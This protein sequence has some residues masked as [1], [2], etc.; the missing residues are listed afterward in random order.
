MAP[1]T[2]LTAAHARRIAIAAQGLAGPRP[3]HRIDLRQLKATFRRLAVLQIDSVNVLTRAHHLPFFSR[4]GPYD[5][6]RLDRWLWRSGDLFEHLAHEAALVPVEQHRLFRHRMQ[7]YRTSRYAPPPSE[8]AYLDAVLAEIAERG[9]LAATDLVDGGSRT[10]PWWGLSRGKRTVRHLHRV[11]DLAIADRRVNFELVYDLAERVI[12][13]A[14]LAAPTPDIDETHR[15]LLRIAARAHGIG[16]V[17]DLADYHR[18]NQT[19]SRRALDSLV[20]EGELA[21]VDVEG[22][23]LPAYLPVDTVVPRRVEARA[24]LSPFDPMIW[25][26]PRIERMFGFHYRIEIY[27]PEPR[28]RFG[29]YVLPFLL[30]ED[31]VARVDL[32]ADRAVGVLRVRASHVEPGHPAAAVAGPLAEELA[33]MA[34]WLGLDGVAVEER[35]DLAVALHR[36][37]DG[38]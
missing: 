11:G 1:R 16:T 23:P 5:R 25:F 13:A 20:A 7:H 35:G 17:A 32:K 28:R 19:P 14:A 24:L 33:L 12:P 8:A 18:L 21:V 38:A 27:V 30:G 6:H 9:P 37:V 22:W 34:E 4:L 15:D 10:G 36:A 2:R 31:L 26:R 29:Y 3:T